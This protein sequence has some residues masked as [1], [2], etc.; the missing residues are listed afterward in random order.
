MTLSGPFPCARAVSGAP[1]RSR[2]AQGSEQQG[3]TLLNSE[4]YAVCTQGTPTQGSSPF[5]P[6]PVSRTEKEDLGKGISHCTRRRR[7]LTG[8]LS[9]LCVHNCTVIAQFGDKT[10]LPEERPQV[11]GFIYTPPAQ[12]Q[13]E[14]PKA[15]NQTLGF[16]RSYFRLA[17][18]HPMINY[19]K[20]YRMWNEHLIF[21]YLKKRAPSFQSVWIIQSAW[22]GKLQLDCRVIILVEITWMTALYSLTGSVCYLNTDVI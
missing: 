16:V 18:L 13:Q 22:K 4:F 10:D 12:P 9:N 19:F 6:S 7:G 2:T 17:K 11:L 21:F 3:Q 15:A 8:T 14:K 5:H 1:G 20:K